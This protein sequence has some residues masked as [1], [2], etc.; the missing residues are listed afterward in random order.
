[1]YHCRIWYFPVVGGI[2]RG[3]D[4]GGRGVRGCM[5]LKKRGISRR[6]DENRKGADTCF[7]TT[8][9]LRPRA[10]LIYGNQDPDIGMLHLR[11]K[12]L[13]IFHIRD[14]RGPRPLAGSKLKSPLTYC[15]RSSKL[16][17]ILFIYKKTTLVQPQCYLK[18]Y[19]FQS[20]ILLE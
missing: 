13:D 6:G 19:K 3:W 5:F 17:C 11:P 8:Q 4:G 18:V 12:I 16:S 9:D 2:K 7:C 20:Q 15:N 10:P 14:L 1:M